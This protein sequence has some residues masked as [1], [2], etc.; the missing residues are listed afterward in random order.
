MKCP[1]CNNDMKNGYVRALGR[2]GICWVN[3]KSDWSAP[4]SDA[5]FMQLGKAPWLKA[6]SIPAFKCDSCK[7]IVIG[8][9]CQGEAESQG[10]GIDMRKNRTSE[11]LENTRAEKWCF[12]KFSI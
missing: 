8:Y 4:R 12:S 6:D 9:N 7:R 5:G 11:S 3:E 10:S 2:G 1:F